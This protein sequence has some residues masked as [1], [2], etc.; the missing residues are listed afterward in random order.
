MAA[1]STPAPAAAL[2]QLLYDESEVSEKCGELLRSLP[3]ARGWMGAPPLYVYGGDWYYGGSLQGVLS[4]LKHFQPHDTDI[5]LASVPKSGT[6]WLKAIGYSIVNRGKNGVGSEDKNPLLTNNPHD[7]VPFLELNLYAAKSVPDVT[8]IPPPRLFA[9]HLSVRKM[10]AKYASC[11]V[12]YI[13]RNPKDTF[14]SDWNFIT[15]LRPPDEAAISVEEAFDMFCNGVN[16]FG[17]YW[18][19]VLEYWNA[20]LE[21]PGSIM[22][23]KYED[24]I[25]QPHRHF[26]KIAEFLGCPF[27]E[28]EEAGGVVDEMVKL[29]SFDHLSGLEVNQSMTSKSLGAPNSIFFRRGGVGD[30]KN[31]LAPEMIDRLDRIAKERFSP[32]G[33][34][35]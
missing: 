2:A 30:S 34:E 20:S 3:K 21:R 8:A 16:A 27:S 4:T 31:L 28:A 17:P 32:L 26:V 24:L 33:L 15:R 7:L 35:F 9:T 23:L 12:L 5:I 6:T 19:H 22:F 25:A 29:C 18:D 13:C 1:A 11:K 10:S 14:T